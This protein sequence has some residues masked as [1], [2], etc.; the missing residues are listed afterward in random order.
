MVIQG[1]T[2]RALSGAVS[3]YTHT[4]EARNV[5]VSVRDGTF[6]DCLTGVLIFGQASAM[7][8]VGNRF[9]GTGAAALQLDPSFVSLPDVNDLDF[10]SRHRVTSHQP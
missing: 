5:R 1:C 4:P 9:W 7:Q 8:V 2:F 6:I 3:I 10:S